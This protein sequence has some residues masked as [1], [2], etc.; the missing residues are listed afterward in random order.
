[1]QLRILSAADVRRALP[2]TA[3]IAAMR[4][5]FAALHAGRAEVPVRRRLSLPG[6]VT[7]FMPASLPDVDGLGEKV[8]SVFAGNRARG[9]PAIHALVTLYDPATGAPRA[10][11]EGGALTA[12]RTGAATGLATDLLARSDA[13]V[14]TVFGAGEQAPAQIEAVLAVRP[15]EE[16]RILS[17]GDSAD[18]LAGRLRASDPARRY[19]AGSDPE[20]AVRAADVIVTATPSTSP[21]FR[22]ELPRPG[23][24]VNAI[25]AFRP[26]MREVD[27]ALLRRAA[28]VVDQRAAAEEE[29]GDLLI[30]AARGEWSFDALHAELGALVAGAAPPPAA[31]ADL[32]LFKSCGLAVQDVAAAAAALAAAEREGL[33]SVLEL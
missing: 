19:R 2:M 4:T 17:R 33:G 32:T 14:L 27:A 28:V 21:L 7:L 16:V 6:G 13:R 31:P 22:G 8:V 20:E 18:R 11:L 1:M 15:V 3:A 30:A 5:A 12:L 23:T 24:H 25:G 26:D 10:L 29:A 9:L